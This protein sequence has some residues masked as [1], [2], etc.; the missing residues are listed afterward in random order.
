MGDFFFERISKW[1]HYGK[2]QV[3]I[4]EAASLYGVGKSILRAFPMMD[5][6][7]MEGFIFKRISRWVPYGELLASHFEMASILKVPM[8]DDSSMEGFFFKEIS[9]WVPCGEF[10]ISSFE[11]TSFHR[12]STS[13]L[14]AS[15]LKDG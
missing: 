1:V 9:R 7:S 3:S 13:I 2:L 12:I 6:S 4:F 8:V 5:G 15:P 10:R 11:M 14:R